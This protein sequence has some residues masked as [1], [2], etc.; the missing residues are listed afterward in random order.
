MSHR[1]VLG[2]SSSWCT[3]LTTRPKFKGE[4]A[5]KKTKQNKSGTA[6][7]VNKDTD[8]ID[9]CE[10]QRIKG[11]DQCKHKYWSISAGGVI[12]ELYGHCGSVTELGSGGNLTSACD[13]A[14]P[15]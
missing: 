6:G 11:G 10:G 8:K 9:M 1:L 12:Q 3:S 2:S 13:E 5:P 7:F 14:S 15:V 4:F